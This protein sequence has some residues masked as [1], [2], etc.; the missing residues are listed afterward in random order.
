MTGGKRR[1]EEERAK[2]RVR[3]HLHVTV[4]EANYTYFPEK[5]P[6]D[7]HSSDLHRRVAVYARVSTGSISQVSSFELQ[8]D[9]YK[10]FVTCLPNL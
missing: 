10:K 9:Y 8:K 7:F 2:L 5:K 1:E 4:D 6:V 3:R